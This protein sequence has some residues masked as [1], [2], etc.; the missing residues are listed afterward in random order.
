ML[1]FF[2]P[3]KIDTFFVLLSWGVTELGLDTSLLVSEELALSFGCKFKWRG[4]TG[5]QT[6]GCGF[7]KTGGKKRF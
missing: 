5:A 2:P 1:F 6:L 7:M 4:V 3:S